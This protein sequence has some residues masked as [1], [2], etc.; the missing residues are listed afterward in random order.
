MQFGKVPTPIKVHSARLP[1]AFGFF[2][3][4]I[5]TLDNKLT[6]PR[7]LV[8][9]IRERVA[10]IKTCSFCKHIGPAFVIKTS[11]NEVKFDALDQCRTSSLFSDA[12]R[13]VLD[14]VTEL[15][16]R[17]IRK[18]LRVCPAIIQRVPF[19]RSFGSSPASISTTLSISSEHSLRHALQPQQEEEP[20]S[21]RS[22]ILGT[23]Y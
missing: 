8:F 5:G 20:R 7:E 4:K 19:A 9:L 18:L 6:L 10:Q 17:S 13:A 14:Y 2:Y 16:K 23:K 15:T 3:G 21:V 12:E 11:M 22:R 1:P